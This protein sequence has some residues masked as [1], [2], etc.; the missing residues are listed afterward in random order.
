MSSQG[1]LAAATG[2]R[3]LAIPRRRGRSGAQ[4]ENG[5]QDASNH[6]PLDFI[7]TYIV[8]API[9]EARRP[10]ALMVRHLL[11]LFDRATGRIIS[12]SPSHCTPRT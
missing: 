11:R 7:E 3:P 5:R 8:S 2:L 9:I 6:N 12:S 10:R 1:V 4:E